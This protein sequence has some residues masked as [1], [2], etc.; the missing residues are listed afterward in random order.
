M[1]IT[2]GV[3]MA[4]GYSLH[5]LFL[6]SPCTE[7]GSSKRC[8]R[9]LYA[10]SGVVIGFIRGLM[11]LR[12]ESISGASAA[13][14]DVL[15]CFQG[16]WVPDPRA[17]LASERMV[18]LHLVVQSPSCVRLCSPMDCTLGLPVLYHPLGFA[19]SKLHT[20][21]YC[22]RCTSSNDHRLADD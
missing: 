1:D 22:R 7:L 5:C 17:A 9:A 15:S 3:N 10:S 4:P 11:G 18:K 8:S 6:L 2:F 13:L 21:W 19:W 20:L 14:W 16:L 12:L